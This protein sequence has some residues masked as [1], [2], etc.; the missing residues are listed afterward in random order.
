MSTGQRPLVGLAKYGGPDVGVKSCCIQIRKIEC[1]RTVGFHPYIKNKISGVARSVRTM[2]VSGAPAAPIS[3][4][5]T[6][7]ESQHPRNTVV[8]VLPAAPGAIT[9]VV[10]HPTTKLK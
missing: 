4:V 3:S 9:P 8:V 1:D 7:S 5:H 6:T 2:S 10:P